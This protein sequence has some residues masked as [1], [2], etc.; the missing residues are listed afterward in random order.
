MGSNPKSTRKRQRSE[1]RYG[2]HKLLTHYLRTV[3]EAAGLKWDGDNYAEAEEIV[4][5]IIDAAAEEAN[6]VVR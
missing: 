5:L 1:K 4:D 6:Y 3:W 2:A